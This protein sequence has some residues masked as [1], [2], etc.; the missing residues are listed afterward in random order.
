MK[1]VYSAVR[2]GSLNKGNNKHEYGTAAETLEIV[3]QCHNDTHMD[4]WETF[5]M[6]TFNKHKILITEQQFSDINSLYE[7]ADTSRIAL[8]PF[9]S[10]QLCL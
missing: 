8:Q 9:T 2:T 4:C 1:S 5:Y 7:L 6:Q 3:K 10:S